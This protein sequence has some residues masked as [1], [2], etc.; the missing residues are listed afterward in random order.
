MSD[1][2]SKREN[3]RKPKWSKKENKKKDNKKKDGRKWVLTIVPIT[4]IISALLQMIQS[5]LMTRVN[6]VMAFIILS[7][8][9]GIGILFDIVGVAVTS[10][11]ETPFHSL[12]SQKVRGAKEAVRL[13]RNA[14][15]V[16]SF[17]NDVI[18]DIAGI[19]SGSAT[20]AIVGMLIVLGG[21]K[22]EFVLG[23]VLTAVVAALTIGGKAI[24]KR[25]AIE[26]SNDIVFTVGK[27]VSFF[28]PVKE[29]NKA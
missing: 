13:I 17:C 26:K 21:T 1:D 7:I 5:G 22:Y 24:G 25:F 19:I 14:D 12:S 4:F 16:G 15:K 20:T 18:G 10:A 28:A 23:I 9:I 2:S 11:N 8:F 6:L 3:V 27:I 29:K